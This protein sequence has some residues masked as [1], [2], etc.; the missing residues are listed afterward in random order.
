MAR[1]KIEDG[2]KTPQDRYR[3]QNIKRME[4]KLDIKTDGDILAQLEG[5]ANKQGYIKSLIRQD[6][7][8][9]ATNIQK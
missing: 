2:Y 4:I 9:D 1:K 6:I 3:A 8:K 7:K 5:I